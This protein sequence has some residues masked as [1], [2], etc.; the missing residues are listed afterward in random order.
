MWLFIF[1]SKQGPRYVQDPM[2]IGE[3]TVY[4]AI[5]SHNTSQGV[6]YL[7]HTVS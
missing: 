3:C 4:L 7:Q 6:S 2:M 5:W 1:H